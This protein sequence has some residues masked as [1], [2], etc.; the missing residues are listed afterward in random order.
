MTIIAFCLTLLSEKLCATDGPAKMVACWYD[1]T[2]KRY[3]LAV[4]LSLGSY[5]PEGL[6]SFKTLDELREILRKLAQDDRILILNEYPHGSKSGRC[7]ALGDEETVKLLKGHLKWQ[8]H[9]EKTTT[10]PP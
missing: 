7:R 9:Q 8:I 4:D 2:L 6:D 1:V 3:A 10:S 5:P